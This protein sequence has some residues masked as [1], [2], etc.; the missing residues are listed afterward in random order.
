MTTNAVSFKVAQSGTRR[1]VVTAPAGR[2]DLHVP[3]AHPR[4]PVAPG[5]VGAAASCSVSRPAAKASPLLALKVAAVGALA[6]LGTVV[7]WQNLTPVEP[8]PALEYV[9]GHPA[10]AHVSQP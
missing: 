1:V 9:A 10:W 5:R 8:D 7:S 4:R 3:S 6:V 2:P